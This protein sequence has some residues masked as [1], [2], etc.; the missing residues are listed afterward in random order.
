MGS[1]NR[2]NFYAVQFVA[3]HSYP[4]D[5]VCPCFR[6]ARVMVVITHGHRHVKQRL[7]VTQSI[8]RVRSNNLNFTF[9][10]G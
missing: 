2:F 1:Y 4:P 5:Q 8:I 7:W 9:A 6:I 10:P 3:R